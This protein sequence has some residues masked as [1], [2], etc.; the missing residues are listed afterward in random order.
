[1]KKLVVMAAAVFLSLSSVKAQGSMAIPT[2]DTAKVKP[3]R[4]YGFIRNY[5][6]YD[7]R[8]TYTVV[9][10]EYNMLPYDVLWN[11]D[12]TTDLNAVPHAQFQ[13]LTSRIG[14]EINGPLLLGMKSSGKIE[15]DFGG[16]GTNNTVLRLRLAYMKLTYDADGL[17]NELLAGQAWHPL[18]GDIMPEVLGMAAGAP[19]RPHSRTPQLRITSYL[20]NVGYTAALLWQ[21]QYMSNGPRSAADSASVAS[22]AYANNAL[23]PELF[24]GINFRSRAFYV[25]LGVDEQLLRPRTHAVRNGVTSKVNETVVSMTPT[26]YAQYTEG[27]W[28]IRFR[29]M[30]AQNTSHLNQMVGYA[31]TGIDNDG[32]WLYDP[33]R[34]TI[35]YLNVAY[36]KRVRV[37]LF[38]GYMKNLGAA[39]NLHD[40]GGGH[41]LI[42]MKGGDLFTHLSSAWRV[43]PS[44]CYNG[45]NIGL[46]LEYEITAATFG[47][48][49]ANGSIANDANLHQVVNH[50][51]CAMAKYTF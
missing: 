27:L 24:M 26:L 38:L 3:I 12:G 37:N 49:A 28:A 7:S 16:F 45:K 10:G 43:V 40:F 22:L 39:R 48:L 32:S 1:M 11:E 13:A 33:M 18:S 47:N 14:L 6:N 51:L 2:G 23:L 35:S 30:L 17:Y 4:V 15:G 34:A 29:T 9:G 19:F 44:V 36:G 50:R 21:L 42:Y 25:Q 31:V 5:F 46:G 8:Q 41:Y 20:G